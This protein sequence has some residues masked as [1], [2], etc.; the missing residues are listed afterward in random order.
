MERKNKTNIGPVPPSYTQQRRWRNQTEEAVLL[1]TSISVKIQPT[2]NS[3]SVTQTPHSVQTDLE[4][5]FYAIQNVHIAPL[6]P[7]VR[8]VV[9]VKFKFACKK[10]APFVSVANR[11][12]RDY[13]SESTAF[14]LVDRIKMNRH[15]VM[16]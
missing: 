2:R 4:R 7:S 11:P 12:C 6:G 15:E 5:F 9:I 1:F 10:V 16:S 3:V 14:S 8:A 13:P